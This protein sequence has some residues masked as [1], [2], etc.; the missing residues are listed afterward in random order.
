MTYFGAPLSA[1]QGAVGVSRDCGVQRTRQEGT[2]TVQEGAGE[3][4]TGR[5]HRQ[6]AEYVGR[7]QG[8]STGRQLASI[9]ALKIIIIIVIAENGGF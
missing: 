9:A 1:E 4:P 5:P 6:P 2:G 8:G 3:L 7:P